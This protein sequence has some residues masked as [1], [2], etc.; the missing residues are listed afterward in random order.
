M[1]L[2]DL[3]ETLSQPWQPVSRGALAVW[4]LC[5]ALFLLYALGHAGGFLFVDNANLVVHEAGHALFGW[6]GQT[7]GL[8]GGTILQ[9]LVPLLLAASFAYKRQTAGVAFCLFLFF[10]NLLYVATY[11]A[12]ARI[13]QL[14]LVSIGGG[15]GPVEHDWYLMFSQLGLLQHDRSIAAVVRTLG[16]L[17][18]AASVGWLWLRGVAAPRAR[19]ARA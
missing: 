18:M 11:M 5:Y 15:D 2:D 8:W 4:S 1:A 6:F 14:D 3:R 13:Q 19:A 10:E 17:G 9:L 12:D 16:Y 7:L